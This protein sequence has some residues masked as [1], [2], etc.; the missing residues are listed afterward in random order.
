VSVLDA[1]MMKLWDAPVWT[2]GMRWG[3]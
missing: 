3:V 2:A 1:E